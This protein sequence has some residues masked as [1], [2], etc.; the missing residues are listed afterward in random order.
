MALEQDGRLEK[1]MA[2]ELDM[3]LEQG[4]ALK[5]RFDLLRVRLNGAVGKAP[6]YGY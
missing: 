4:Q 6:W 3:H 1:D 5:L 2:L